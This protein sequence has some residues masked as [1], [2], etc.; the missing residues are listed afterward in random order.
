MQVEFT[1]GPQLDRK[2]GGG[3][4]ETH[5]AV[6][7]PLQAQNR[8]EVDE[9]DLGMEHLTVRDVGRTD[10][11]D[12]RQTLR[13]ERVAARAEGVQRLA[14]AEKDGLLAL[15]HD[16]LR[17]INKVLQRVLPHQRLLRPL[18]FQHRGAIVSL[19]PCQRLLHIRLVPTKRTNGRAGILLG[20]QRQSTLL[21]GDVHKALLQGRR[22][23]GVPANRAGRLLAFGLV[24]DHLIAAVLALPARQ[25]LRLHVDDI[26]ATARQLLR[27]EQPAQKRLGL[28]ILPAVGTLNR[29]RLRQLHHSASLSLGVGICLVQGI[30]SPFL[31]ERIHCYGIIE[32]KRC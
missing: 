2:A 17:A 19:G 16:E 22:I 28:D 10:L 14:I 13:L 23:D 30:E 27:P 21:A 6:G 24:E 8:R 12:E 11:T 3:I 32:V 25:L 4:E 15:V 29:K 20:T 7:A 26:T 5:F 31:F 1:A 18:E 9:V